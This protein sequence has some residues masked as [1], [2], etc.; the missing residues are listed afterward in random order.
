VRRRVTWAF[1]GCLAVVCRWPAAPKGRG[2]GMLNRDPDSACVAVCN[3]LLTSCG[4]GRTI[5]SDLRRR[6]DSTDLP[7]SRPRS[8]PPAPATGTVTP[9]AAW[10]DQNGKPL[11]MH[12]LGIVKVGATWYAFGE[13]KTG[14]SASNTSFQ[15]IPCYSSTDLRSW[16]YQSVALAR[17]GSGDL[18]PN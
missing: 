5:P 16:T 13:D 10:T 17:Q 15:D 12:G 8:T 7:R 11:Q 9:G 2:Q 1:A 4:F 14:E 18:G 6:I 3:T